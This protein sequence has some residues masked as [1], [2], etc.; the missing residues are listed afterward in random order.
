[1]LFN[2]GIKEIP[3]DF[4]GKIKFRMIYVM[5]ECEALERIDERAFLASADVLRMF[6]IFA[7]NIK[8][9]NSSSY[10][11][12]KLINSSPKL[13]SLVY[14]S[15]IELLEENEIG[16]MTK[17]MEIDMVVNSIKGSPFKNMK[18]LN[19]ITLTNLSHIS[20]KTFEIGENDAKKDTSFQLF[21]KGNKLDGSNF[22]V[23]AFTQP[24]MMKRRN[25]LDF[26]SNPIKFLDKDVFLPFLSE[27][28]GNK[29]FINSKF[30]CGHQR[31]SWFCEKENKQLISQVIGNE[32]KFDC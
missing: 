20:S 30:D 31:N 14:K 22:E 3:E 21:L 32:C 25:F 9:T 23:G 1:M 2:S 17:L 7:K 26:S 11:F 12:A 27:H 18:L 4:H 15:V 24:E 13:S 19:S 29:I 6:W 28:K 8:D 5:D 10:S 16:N